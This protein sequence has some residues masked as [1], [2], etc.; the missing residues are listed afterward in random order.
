MRQVQTLVQSP[1]WAQRGLEEAGGFRNGRFQYCRKYCVW[2]ESARRSPA[3]AWGGAPLRHSAPLPPLRPPPPPPRRAAPPGACAEAPPQRARRGSAGRRPRPPPGGR[4]RAGAECTSPGALCPWG[5][6]AR[7]ASCLPGP[8]FWGF[9]SRGSQAAG[10][11]ALLVAPSGL[12]VVWPESAPLPEP[13][14]LRQPE[15]GGT[16]S[17]EGRLA[18]CRRMFG[19][20]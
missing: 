20:M 19:M 5:A 9:G 6:A 7:H 13:A 12:L 3:L 2:G 10:P 8:A 17:E 18:G 11:A 16:S 15:T 14:P 4:P 1:R